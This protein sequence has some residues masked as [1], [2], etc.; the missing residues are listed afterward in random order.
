MSPDAPVDRSTPRFNLLFSNTELVIAILLGVVSIATAYASFSASLY[1][2]QMAGSYTTGQNLTTEAESLYLEANQQ[3]TLDSQVWNQLSELA[4]E[5]DSTDATVA[6]LANDKYD[7]LYFQAV[8]PD[9]DAAIQRANDA[10]EADPT[11]YTSPLDDEDY[12]AALFTP[13]AETQDKATAAIAQGDDYNSLGDKLTL[14]TVLMAISLFLLGVAAVVRAQKVQFVLM[15]TAMVI[16][17][18]AMVLTVLIPF[19][20]M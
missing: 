16:F 18:G 1:G 11:T 8:S 10:N 3:Y 19:P 6:A 9:F 2:G 4:V 14:A 12:Q 13:Y 7:T 5:I 15:G 20:G 17:V